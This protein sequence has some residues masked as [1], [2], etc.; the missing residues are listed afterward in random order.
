MKSRSPKR[1]VVSSSRSENTSDVTSEAINVKILT[2]LERL[3]KH[4]DSIE[5]ID[6][7][8]DVKSEKVKRS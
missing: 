7:K 5:Q 8:Q 4:L 3:D 6:G 2:Q 1:K